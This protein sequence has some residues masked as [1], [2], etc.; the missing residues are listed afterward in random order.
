MI[1]KMKSFLLVTILTASCVQA[2]PESAA[3]AGAAVVGAAGIYTTLVSDVKPLVGLVAVCVTAVIYKKLHS[4]TPAGRIKRAALLLNEVEK[5]ILARV[6]YENDRDLF[7]EALHMQYESAL[8]LIEASEDLIE[9]KAILEAAFSLLRS[10]ES[11]GADQDILTAVDYAFAMDR[12]T[13]FL[14]NVT[15]ASE[16]VRTHPDYLQQL[17]VA[18]Q[19]KKAD[20]QEKQAHAHMHHAHVHGKIADTQHNEFLFKLFKWLFGNK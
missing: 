11:E 3:N 13:R 14:F 20:A 17:N 1:T 12:A 16:L 15:K 7:S 9:L 18:A 2:I 10:A 8:P 4:I 6:D 5:N 19:Q